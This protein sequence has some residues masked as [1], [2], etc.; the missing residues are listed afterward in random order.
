MA[1]YHTFILFLIV[2]IYDLFILDLIF[3][4]NYKKVIIKGTEDM[5]KECKNPRHHIKR[6][7]I[8]IGFGGLV[9]FLVSLLIALLN[10]II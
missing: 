7:V 5:I 3:F 9:G 8:G 1:F 6:A 4:C 2:N 10:R